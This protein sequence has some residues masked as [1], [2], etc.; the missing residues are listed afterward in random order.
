M[1]LDEMKLAWRQIDRK[2]D[3]L[4]SANAD[5]RIEMGV[6]KAWQ[7]MWRVKALIWSE[8][9]INGAALV[10]LGNYIAGQTAL[11]FIVPALVLYPAAIATFACTIAQIVL[12]AR[13]EY[14]APVLV[15]Q[16]QLESL[17]VLRLRTVQAEFL[18]AL[19]LWMPFAIVL[20]H[21]LNGIDLYALGAVWMASNVTLGVVTVPVLWWVAER[22]GPM[23]NRSAFGRNLLDDLTGRGLA[24]AREQ[25]ATI[26]K[27]VAE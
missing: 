22:F 27:F 21:A 12:L 14:S 8:A 2:L 7:S 26:T 13:I 20:M 15:I 1:E 10:L 16:R 18:S 17:R 4:Q 23:L 11:R 25:I 24:A 19:L 6:N 5:L 3:A 9:I